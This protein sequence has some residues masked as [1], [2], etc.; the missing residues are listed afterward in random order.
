MKVTY[1]RYPELPRFLKTF[2]EY[3][4]T[5]LD[6]R[7]FILFGD[8]VLDD[9][10]K[11]YS[12]IDVIVVLEKSLWER[13]FDAIDEIIRNLGNL[14]QEFT[15]ILRAFFVPFEML[16]NPRVSHHDLEG[17]VVLNSQQEVLFH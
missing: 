2:V 12:T 13:D 16:A 7:S 17:M 9:F 5:S 4:A 3:T 14:N 1:D 10:S 15:N 6:T 11:R 8:I